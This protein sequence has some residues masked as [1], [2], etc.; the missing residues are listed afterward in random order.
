MT[1]FGAG[2]HEADLL[3]T[4]VRGDDLFGQLNFAGAWR[5]ERRTIP[6]HLRDGRDHRWMRMTQNQRTPRVYEVQ[7]LT[8]VG[9]DEM[10][11]RTALN[12]ERRAPHRFE[13]AYG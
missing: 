8:P 12:E 13:C 10:L 7:V 9:V 3:Q 5:S 1:A 6:R 4:R 11:S 2:G